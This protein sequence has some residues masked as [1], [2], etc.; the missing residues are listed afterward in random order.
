V[1]DTLSGIMQLLLELH[2]FGLCRC[3]IPSGVMTFINYSLL[4]F[5]VQ[6]HLGSE[7]QTSNF[8][9]MLSSLE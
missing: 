1:V 5:V 6:Y 9:V 4:V 2:I 8:G 3:Q 7:Y